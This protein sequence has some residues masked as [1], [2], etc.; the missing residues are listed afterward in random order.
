MTSA[1]PDGDERL[2]AKTRDPEEGVE[3]RTFTF[4]EG[5]EHIGFGRFHV[6]LMIVCGVGWFAEILELVIMAFVAPAIEKDMG[7][8]AVEYGLLGSS[9]FIGMAIGAVFWGALS[10]RFGRFIGFTCTTAMTFIF[11]VASAFAPN[12]GVLLLFRI[13]ACVGVGGT[14]PVDYAHLVEFL[15][16]KGRGRNMAIVDGIGVIP[17]LFLGSLLAYFATS[18]VDGTNWRLILG[19]QSIPAGLFTLIRFFIPES[20]RYLLNLNKKEEAANVLRRVARMCRK[21]A[22]E[23]DLEG[24][25]TDLETRSPLTRFKEILSPE[26]RSTTWR[27]WLM[28]FCAQFASAGFVFAMPKLFESELGL[29]AKDVS[30]MI[31]LGVVGVIP[32]LLIAFF[33]I[34]WS[35]KKSVSVFYL[36]SALGVA[37]FA[38]ATMAAGSVEF[39]VAASMV[40]RGGME[41]MFA[42]LNTIRVEVYPT[43]NR[44]SAMGTSQVLY[45][46]GGAIT[47]LIFGAM[48]SS[49]TLAALCLSIYAGAYALSVLP[50]LTLPRK[51]DYAGRAVLDRIT[52]LVPTTQT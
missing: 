14:L 42:I 32:G 5:V 49:R 37:L 24:Y 45:N 1:E 7:L 38:V 47:T 52:Q 34:E 18:R 13:L 8:S 51:S 35:R 19:V 11:S 39:A 26:L 3:R 31:L 41:G 28:A 12:Y 46:L 6:F 2:M 44:I 4:E 17:A 33:A 50:A 27:V 30:L 40:S 10:D 23:G 43:T 15:P 25:S 21:Q 20:P 29:P 16:V 48:S 22:P 9:S 36:A